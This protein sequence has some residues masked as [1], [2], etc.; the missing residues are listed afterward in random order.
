M[1]YSEDPVMLGYEKIWKDYELP[2]QQLWG[3][4]KGDIPVL[5]G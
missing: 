5:R 1:K 3:I 2:P 4:E